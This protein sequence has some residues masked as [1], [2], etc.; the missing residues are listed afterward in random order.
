MKQ[1]T[2]FEKIRDNF[3]PIEKLYNKFFYT[4]KVASLLLKIPVAEVNQETSLLFLLQR[5]FSKYELLK[6]HKK[7]VKLELKITSAMSRFRVYD[8]HSKR[9]VQTVQVK[10]GHGIEYLLL[11]EILEKDFKFKFNY[12]PEQIAQDQGY[13]LCADIEQVINRIGDYFTDHNRQTLKAIKDLLKQQ[14]LAKKLADEE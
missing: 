11:G 6:L 14:E 7:Q 3:I 9:Y 12:T 13:A 1:L 5:G 4:D 10:Y 2:W 8:P